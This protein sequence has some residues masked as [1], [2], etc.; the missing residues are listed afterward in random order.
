MPDYE[1]HVEHLRRCHPDHP[2]PSERQY[3]EEFLNARYTDGP[4]RCC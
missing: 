3:Y 2:I 4:T 1:H